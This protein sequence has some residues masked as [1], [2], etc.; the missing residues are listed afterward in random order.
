VAGEIVGLIPDPGDGLIG[1]I[2]SDEVLNRA[3]R[4]L[5]IQELSDMG[6][7]L[8]ESALADATRARRHEANI[9]LSA[10]AAF[11]LENPS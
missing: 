7:E 11:L 4:A 8:T 6:R 5:A 2:C 1:R 10:A 3:A 9:V